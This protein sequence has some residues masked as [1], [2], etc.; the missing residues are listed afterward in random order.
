M[1]GW[2]EES[3]RSCAGPA[4][5]E[6]GGHSSARER[7]TVRAQPLAFLHALLQLL[8]VLADGV[9]WS[10][11]RRGRAEHD[12]IMMR[13]DSCTNV[14][15]SNVGHMLVF[16]FACSR[17]FSGA[18]NGCSGAAA[19]AEQLAAKRNAGVDVV[20]KQRQRRAAGAWGGSSGCGGGGC[21]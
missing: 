4:A 2:S 18:H 1:V 6:S 7:A 19:A 15:R 14:K 10:R 21:I 20:G 5:A 12:A 13:R 3:K 11:R 9:G 8:Q 17:V 16:M